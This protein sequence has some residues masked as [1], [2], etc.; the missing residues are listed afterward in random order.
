MALVYRLATVSYRSRVFPVIE[1]D[2]KLFDFNAGYEAFKLGS[3]RRDF[4]KAKHEYTML[5]ILDEWDLFDSVLDDVAKFLSERVSGSEKVDF[6]YTP[7]E[8]QFLPPILYPD[9]VLNAGSNYYDHSREMGAAPPEPDIQ[10]PYFFYKGSRHTLT[11]HG[12]PVRLT[13]RSDYT[14]WEAEIALVIGRTAKNVS[15]KDAYDYI[16]GYTCYNDISA[17]DRMMRKNETFDFDW[18]SN[19]GNDGFG[20]I[21][22]Y[23][24]PRKFMPDISDLHIKCIH[25]GDVVQNFSMKN[26][27]YDIP[28]LI[29]TATSVTTL[30]PGDVI[31]CGTGAGAGMANGI[32]VGWNEIGKVF[33]H[34]YAG[35]ARLLHAGDTIAVEIDGIGRLENRIMPP[36]NERPG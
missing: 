31:A 3:G 20:P 32:K 22:P 35:K 23:I 30:S 34:M 18:F 9:K 33:E 36:S 27:V 12:S 4:F 17:R 2:G 28:R 10:E 7:A 21:G 11:G 8:V 1:V 19:K 6:V 29:E 15:R 24:L 26:I 13:P 16:A 5:D 14:D 25:N